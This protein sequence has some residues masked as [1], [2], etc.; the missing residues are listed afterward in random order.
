[1]PVKLKIGTRE[2]ELAIW[3]AK[4]IQT[5]LSKLQID[6][7]LVFVKSDGE[8]NPTE[9][10]YEMGVQGIFTKALDVALLN[11]DIDIA[12]HSL[13]DVPTQLAK[14]LIL[15]AVLKRGSFKDVLVY[16]D[17]LPQ[18]QDSYVVATSSLRRSAQWLHKF[19]KHSTA[20]LRGN[21][22]TRLKKLHDNTGWNGALFAAAGIER[23]QLKVPNMLE[24][25][26]MIPAPA[27]GA[28]GIVCREN[29][30]EMISVCSQMN[31]DN[32]FAE[33]AF[34]RSFLRRLMG[35][36]SM[37]IGALAQINNDVLHFKGC[38]LTVDGKKM[39][40]TEVRGKTENADE[41]LT[42]A[43]DILLQQGGA[44]ILQTFKK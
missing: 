29:D 15:A 9:P 31:D 40:T 41:L 33:T 25:D 18:S 6:S 8:L 34:E 20:V 17:V 28:I 44:E 36:C 37:P 35:G 43:I 10:L 32:T 5:Q 11:N 14:G 39:S 38:V 3:Q 42:E 22:N 2:S 1:M 26:W 30:H 27:Q 19:P 16:K 13:K 24:L 7:E 21:I 12:V 23:I 4:L